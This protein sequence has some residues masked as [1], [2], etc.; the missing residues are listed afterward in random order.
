MWL[1]KEIYT[2]KYLYMGF[3]THM[4]FLLCEKTGPRS[5]D[6]PVTT[7]TP[8]IQILASNSISQENEPYSFL[9]ILG[10]GQE[11]EIYKMSLEYLLMLE[12]KK[13]I[14]KKLKLMEIYQRDTGAN[15]NSSQ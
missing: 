15:S 3:C 2:D 8:S 13:V 11:M 9:L 4:Y 10:L 5:N 6:T 14:K 7:R 1:H 12:S